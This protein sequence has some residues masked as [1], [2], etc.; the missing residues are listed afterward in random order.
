MKRLIVNADD[1]GFHPS[2]DAGVFEAY[3][4]GIVTSATVL[5]TG[6]SAP[7]A[8]EKALEL[9]LPLGLHA[10]LTSRLPPAAPASSVRWLAP[11]GRLRGSWS[12]LVGALT[13]GLIPKEEIELELRS[14]VS[15]LRALGA[16]VD[17]LDAHQHV[18][19]FPSLSPIFETLALELGVPIRWPQD[20]PGRKWLSDPKAAAKALLLRGLSATTGTVRAVRVRAVGVFE[21]G[22]L[23]ERYLVDLLV[24]LPDGTCELMCHP[25]FAPGHVPQDPTWRYAWD[26][27]RKALTN[28]LV[29]DALTANGVEL[30]SYGQL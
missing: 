8:V 29:R 3:E 28:P 11:G 9:K 6:P 27:E 20:P 25:G 22:K 10:A 2:I 12:E 15:R 30:I 16:T 4:H 19:L 5:A 21:S 23:D 24:R 18:H 14:Q 7:K 1:L 17:H 13:A 26:D